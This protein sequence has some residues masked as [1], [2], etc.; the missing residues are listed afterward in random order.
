MKRYAVTKKAV[1]W[2]RW[3][4]TLKTKV[5]DFIATTGDTGANR[6]EIAEATQLN[7]GRVS[8]YLAEL[9]REG[10]VQKLGEQVDPSTLSAEDS[11]LYALGALENAL[12]AK[13]TKAG[14]VTQEQEKAFV[15]YQKIK[16]LFLGA[17]TGGEESSAL[18]MAVIE[19]VKLVF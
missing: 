14:K 13:A 2:S 15:R 7:V 8:S 17:R 1:T 6:R 5:Y 18:R 12:I 16:S 10:F 19:L 11:I 3:Q 9:K 4:T